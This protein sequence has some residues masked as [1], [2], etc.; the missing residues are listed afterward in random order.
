MRN[1][2]PLLLAGLLLFS[3]RSQMNEANPETLRKAL[4]SKISP[5]T[6]LASA[7]D[8]MVEEGFV[9]TEMKNSSFQSDRLHSGIDY[10]YCDRSI[11]GSSMVTRRDQVAVVHQ[12]GVV[13]EILVSTGLVGP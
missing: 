10:L 7:K 12:R 2:N 6:S 5:G 3:C 8:K 13:T 9:C 11:C 4:L 1:L